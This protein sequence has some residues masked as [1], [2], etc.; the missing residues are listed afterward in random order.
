MKL[1]KQAPG[2]SSGPFFAQNIIQSN[3]NNN[4]KLLRTGEITG[5]KLRLGG[6]ADRGRRPNG[7]QVE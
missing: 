7:A 2:P 6:K 4:A 1:Y 5:G 3:G